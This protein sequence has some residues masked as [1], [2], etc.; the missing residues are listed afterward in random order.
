MADKPQ[1][2]GKSFT[3]DWLVQG[4]LTKIGDA[5]D[6]L[7]G[8][9]WKPSSSLATS[10]LIERLKALLDAEAVEKTAGRK[11][12]PHSIKLRMQW[13][14]FSTD[15]DESLR[16]LE[17]E[18]LTATVD[19]INDKRYYTLAPISLEVKPD[20]FTNGVKLFVSFDTA[21][22]DREAAID[23]TLPGAAVAAIGIPSADISEPESRRVVFRFTVIGKA[24]EKA[25]TFEPK[26]RLSVGRTRENDLV[27]DDHSVS[28]IHASL[29]LNSEHKLLVADTGSTNGTFVDGQ[30]IPYGK[31]VEIGT[32][33]PL[34]F[35]SVDVVVEI[36]P[37]AVPEPAEIE[38]PPKTETYTV[39]EFEFTKP[40]TMEEDDAKTATAV[41]NRGTLKEQET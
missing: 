8:R 20:Y 3:P 23:V 10:E 7:L 37:R 15:S 35:G 40:L 32:G 2:A 26:K 31:A 9:G 17:T 19:H 5:F 39:G 25:L 41:E 34:K 30:R 27:I 13:D 22:D 28:K 14:K 36:A 38:E 6:R 11:Y 24:I 21:E 12:V 4:I 1:T 33:T 29:F 18:L 16:K